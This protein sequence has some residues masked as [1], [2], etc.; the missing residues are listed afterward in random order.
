MSNVI[1]NSSIQ[2]LNDD[3]QELQDKSAQT[4]IIRVAEAVADAVRSTLGPKGLDKMIVTS[5]GQV[6]ITNTGTD[7]LQKLHINDPVAKMV[8]EVAEAQQLEVGDGTTTAVIFASELLRNAEKLL[9]QNVHPTTIS[10]GYSLA[11]DRATEELDSIVRQIDVE[12]VD[13]LRSIAKT[14]ITGKHADANDDHLSEIIVEAIRS[15]TV[16]REEGG[17]LVDDPF[18][19][20]ET[21]V[22][23][24]PKASE[25]LE[26]MVLDKSPVHDA[27]PTTVED[28]RILLFNRPLQI[29]ETEVSATLSIKDPEQLKNHLKQE[30]K[31]VQRLVQRIK[32]SGANVVLC[33]K[34]IDEGVQAYLAKEGILAVRRVKREHIGFLREVLGA[35][36]LSDVDGLT[37]RDLGRAQVSYDEQDGLLS[38]S[39]RE[40]KAHGVTIILR[41]AT[42]H[43]VDELERGI[44]TAFNAVSQAIMDQRIVPGGGATEV[45]ISKTIRNDAEEIGGR[46]QLALKAFADA[47]EEVPRVLA[48]NAGFD[49]I[50][51]LVALRN[52]HTENG[53]TAGVDADTG[54][55]KDTFESGI[56]EPARV[57]TSVIASGVDAANL[58]LRIDNVISASHLDETEPDDEKDSSVLSHAP[59]DV[60]GTPY[61]A[62]EDLRE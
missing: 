25:L 30:E 1:K 14:S 50:E 34:A 16:E 49:P 61:S 35:S 36:I 22:G 47:L 32:D 12:D 33:Q 58:L 20:I 48:T 59:E 62:H 3:Y 11:A 10:R 17:Y 45:A 57:K 2:L 26:G 19:M 4:H 18:I 6:T 27:M 13:M 29:E 23:D 42:D 43:A 53:E 55:I 15:V 7:I 51:I 21:Q 9:E 60:W 8:I 5:N 24:S 41:G 39:S 31:Q 52:S 28:A 46:E 40:D 56:V 38:I 54:D 37:G 44:D